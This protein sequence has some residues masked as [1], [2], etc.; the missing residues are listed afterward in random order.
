VR[1]HLYQ[2]FGAQ[3]A[4][5]CPHEPRKASDPYLTHLHLATV[6]KCYLQIIPCLD[7]YIHQFTKEEP[8]NPLR[9]AVCSSQQILRCI[10]FISIISAPAR[11]ASGAPIWSFFW[12]GLM[13]RLANS[14]RT[15]GSPYAPPQS[16]PRLYT[17][18]PTSLAKGAGAF[19]AV[20]GTPSRICA[21][22]VANYFL[23]P[24]KCGGDSTTLGTPRP[25]A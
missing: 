15:T 7:M 17:P 19:S 1:Y 20:T 13:V 5:G 10:I 24:A 23:K 21:P 2:I 16:R 9:H 25:K 11:N 14:E 18:E 12:A 3:E 4:R 6:P 8:E 22:N